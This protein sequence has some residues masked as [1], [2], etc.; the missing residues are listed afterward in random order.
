[1]GGRVSSPSILVAFG[2]ILRIR[3]LVRCNEVSLSFATALGMPEHLLGLITTS[4]RQKA[5][6][7]LVR[8]LQALNQIASEKRVHRSLLTVLN[9]RQRA[10]LL[11]CSPCLANAMHILYDLPRQVIVDDQTDRLEV[12]P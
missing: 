8:L 3:W 5:G 12:V 11:A 4:F 2:R 1:M 7:R 9:E 6:H 10:S